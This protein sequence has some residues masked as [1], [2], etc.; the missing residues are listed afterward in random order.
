[1]SP[2]ADLET[3]LAPEIDASSIP[4]VGTLIHARR[5]LQALLLLPVHLSCFPPLLK[6]RVLQ[7]HA[8][9]GHCAVQATEGTEERRRVQNGRV[10]G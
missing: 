1:M 2:L 4:A 10:H 7:V 3:R 8:S 6:S 9:P 5:S